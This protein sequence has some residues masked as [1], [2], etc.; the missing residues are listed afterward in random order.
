MRAAASRPLRGVLRR[1][2]AAARPLCGAPGM[3][4]AASGPLRGTPPR[5]V[6]AARP[7][8]GAMRPARSVSSK[9]A[10]QAYRSAEA[11][12][13][14]SRTVWHG[15]DPDQR[16]VC[17]KPQPRR[18]RKRSAGGAIFRASGRGAVERAS[19]R[20]GIQPHC[21]AE[22]TGRRRGIEPHPAAERTGRRRE[23]RRYGAVERASRR[24]GIQPHC[25]AARTGRRRVRRAAHHFF[26]S[27]AKNGPDRT[28][29]NR[30]RSSFMANDR[31]RSAA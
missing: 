9:I 28:R 1:T 4:A 15:A 6:A 23:T 5:T 3:R 29:P 31:P 24:R 19:R 11:G 26:T 14:H 18:R 17:G 7:L 30:S 27:N 16:K 13:R 10:P 12:I 22:R 25:A 2:G 21:A 20:R 8:H